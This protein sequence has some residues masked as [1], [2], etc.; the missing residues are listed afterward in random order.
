MAIKCPKCGNKIA[1]NRLTDEQINR[2]DKI[3]SDYELVLNR[4]LEVKKDLQDMKNMCD[5]RGEVDVV[6]YI[7]HF[8]RD[9]SYINSGE[10]R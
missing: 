10:K 4:I 5:R 7:D 6:A 1:G 2:Y 8:I 9:L 3:M